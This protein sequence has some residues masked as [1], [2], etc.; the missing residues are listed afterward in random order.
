[1]AEAVVGGPLLRIAQDRVG[2]V[3]FLEPGLGL[4]IAGIAV[5][6]VL[7]GEL[8][9][10]DLQLSLGA[11]PFHRQDFVIVARHLSVDLVYVRHGTAPDPRPARDG[12]Y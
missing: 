1:M 12:G 6:V 5:G 9:E 10:G 4:G 2:L 7:H 3:Q 11:G 8:A